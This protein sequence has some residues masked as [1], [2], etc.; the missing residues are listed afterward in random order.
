MAPRLCLGNPWL[1]ASAKA[2]KLLPA[3]GVWSPNR[4]I[5]GTGNTR[6]ELASAI[7][8]YIAAFHN[9]DRR[10]SALGGQ[11]PTDFEDATLKRALALQV[12]ARTNGS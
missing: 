7:F 5:A 8:E 3:R 6:V 9:H 2:R 1:V 11:I 10:N 4:S 12:C